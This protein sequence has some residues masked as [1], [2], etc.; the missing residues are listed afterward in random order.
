MLPEIY[1]SFHVTLKTWRN[2]LATSCF[3]SRIEM[4]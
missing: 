3:R 4:N 2:E 1:E